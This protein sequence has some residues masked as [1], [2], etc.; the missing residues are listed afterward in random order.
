M[1]MFIL[2]IVYIYSGVYVSDHMNVQCTLC[3]CECTVYIVHI[4]QLYIIIVSRGKRLLTGSYRYGM[5]VSKNRD[6]GVSPRQG[7]RRSR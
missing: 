6:V 2:K 4:S 7:L 1:F 5:G 3:V